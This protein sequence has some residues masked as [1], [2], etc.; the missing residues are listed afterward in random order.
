M[1][2]YD[3]EFR[4]LRLQNGLYIQRHGPMLRLAVPYG[5]LSAAQ[6]RKL[7]D[8]ARR[9][10]RGSATSPRARTCSSTGFS[11]RGARR[12]SPSWPSVNCMRSRP[13][14]TASATSPPTISPASPPTRS[15]IPA[16]GE[17]L[18]QW[19]TFHPEFA[20]LPRKFKIAV[21]APAED[22]AVI[23]A[24]DLGL[25]VVR[26]EQRRDRFQ[27]LCRRRPRPH[28]D[29]R[30]GGASEFLPW[31]HLLSYLE[32]I[33]RVY[34]RYG[35]RDNMYK[36]R[37]KILVKALGIEEFA[38]Q[39]EAEWAHLQGR[40]DDGDRRRVRARAGISPP[41]AGDL[42]AEGRPVRTPTCARTRLSPTGS[43][44]AC[45][46]TRRRATPPSPCR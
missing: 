15:P 33:L 10:D 31:Q 6:L 27:G 30:P 7:A 44:A 36:A 16:L 20:F 17:I 4:P 1:Y 42:P 41:G 2:R 3:D 38:R 23:R 40:P 9:Y 11:C 35:R 45:M 18:R 32:A 5:L 39:V 19:S 29:P 22:R 12:S 46:R 26:D 43:S 28:P 37:I 8:I 34:N 24:H 13:R 14:A 21:N 25:Q